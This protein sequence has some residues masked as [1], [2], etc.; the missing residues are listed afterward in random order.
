MDI[1]A[2]AAVNAPP[3]QPATSAAAL[4]I[5]GGGLDSIVRILGGFI[6]S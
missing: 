2:P 6:C 4:D 5:F 3:S 1:S